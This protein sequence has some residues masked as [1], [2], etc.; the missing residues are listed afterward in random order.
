MNVWSA[1]GSRLPAAW[2]AALLF[3]LLGA[4]PA[5]AQDGEQDVDAV[6]QI[7]S[8]KNAVADALEPWLADNAP[9]LLI[10]ILGSPLWRFFAL[11]LT[12][13]VFMGLRY[14]IVAVTMRTVRN[15]T[16]RTET[17]I[18][19]KLVEATDPP[20]G[21]IVVVTGVYLGLFWPNFSPAVDS[22]LDVLYRVSLIIIVGWGLL[23]SVHI[24]TDLM[25]TVTAHTDSELD[26]Y[27]VPLMARILRIAVI[28]LIVVFA[29]QEFGFNVAGLLAGLGVG[30]LAFALAA[31][32]TVANWFGALMIYTD[33]P[34]KR[35]D[36]VKTPD[37]EGVVEEIG[38]RSTRV[39]TFAKTLVSIPNSDIAS[40]TVENYSAMP[41][42]RV[43]FKMG[44]TYSTTPN[45]M[46]ET[47]AQFKQ[48]LREHEGV[49]QTFWMV[50]FDEFADSSLNILVY[51]FTTTTDWV[52]YM[53]TKQEINLMFMDA[54]SAVGVEAAFPSRSV[55]MESVD[56]DKL[57]ELDDRAAKAL[58]AREQA[59]DGHES[60]TPPVDDDSVVE[61]E[62]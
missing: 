61:E 14:L 15:L 44:L 46:R 50:A 8:V 59:T 42:R 25:Y 37:L 18:D 41:R 9:W 60:M 31:Q 26:D 34:F 3:L 16:K 11:V 56:D 48:I 55:Y 5:A 28:A 27:L 10:D 21:W 47:L 17:D 62:G 33:Q 53:E 45:L 40:G 54:M 43:S 4:R 38:L 32:D 12:I 19:D 39:R 58:A 23:R 22:V 7:S 57:R 13:V 24:L 29:L 35:G 20:L 51:Y 30:G 36:W 2:V 1:L 49:D 52:E 6:G